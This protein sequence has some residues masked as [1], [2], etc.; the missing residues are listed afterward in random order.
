LF[1][2]PRDRN[3][4]RAALQSVCRDEALRARL[5][6]KARMRARRYSQGA[7]VGAYMRLYGEMT[8][9]PT[10]VSKPLP[11]TALELVA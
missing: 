6:A 5:Q 7:M 8:A 11:S 4:L 10:R 9:A 3:A 2:G 1:F